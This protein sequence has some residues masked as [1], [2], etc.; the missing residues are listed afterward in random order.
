MTAM[1][2]TQRQPSHQG[3]FYPANPQ[4]LQQQLD[5]FLA[6]DTP[7]PPERIKALIV[8]HAAYDYSGRVA[9]QAY[10][11]LSQQAPFKRIVILAPNH[12]NSATDILLCS[13]EHWAT[14]LGESAIDQAFIH[15][16][17]AGQPGVSVDDE[18]HQA[19]YSIEV[20]LPFLQRVLS[21][22][23]IVPVLPGAGDPAHLR[24]LLQPIWDD[25]DTLIMIS[26]DLYHYLPRQA[27]LQAGMQTARLIENNDYKNLQ[28]EQA[29]GS[30]ALRGMMSLVEQNKYYWRTLAMQHSGQ[31]N[32][33]NAATYVGYGAFLLLNKPEQAPL[34]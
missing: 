34:S 3:V 16:H 8:P 5:Y 4:V 25:P 19:E 23:P 24:H 30:I 20:Q 14:P 26:S 15:Q 29:C 10:A 21:G 6:T 2:A 22:V 13:H 27:A 32:R 31:D 17:W 12:Q 11:A 18:T 1:T 7:A 33:Y 9:G 28:P